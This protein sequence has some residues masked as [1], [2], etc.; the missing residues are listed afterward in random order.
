MRKLVQIIVIGLFCG[1]AAAAAVFLVLA[2]TNPD[3]QTSY[4]PRKSA[5]STR[6]VS[7]T[8]NGPGDA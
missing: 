5:S 1:G 3:S 2:A 4:R 6:A 7:A 8:A